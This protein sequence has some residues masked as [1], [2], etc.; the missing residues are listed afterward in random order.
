MTYQEDEIDGGDKYKI[1][2]LQQQQ[3]QEKDQQ[4]ESEDQP[5]LNYQR[6]YIM[7]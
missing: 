5:P 1:W 3:T 4:D 6:K 2:H 7:Q